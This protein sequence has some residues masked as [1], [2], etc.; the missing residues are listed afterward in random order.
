MFIHFDANTQDIACSRNLYLDLKKLNCSVLMVTHI[1][2]YN[3]L[4]KKMQILQHTSVNDFDG[5]N[6]TLML[7][8]SFL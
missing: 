4:K 6:Q 3:S 7:E 5:T 2:Y 8:A 1:M